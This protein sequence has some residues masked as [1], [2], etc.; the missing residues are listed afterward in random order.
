MFHQASIFH[1]NGLSATLAAGAF[2]VFS[3]SPATSSLVAGFVSD[4]IGPKA[5]LVFSMATLVAT[6]ALGVSINSLLVAVVYIVMMG[7]LQWVLHHRSQHHLGPL[8]RPPR[9]G[10]HSRAGH[11]PLRLC[12]G[13]RPL[14]LFQEL[15]GTYTL[16]MI[17]MMALPVLSLPV[18]LLTRPGQTS[19]PE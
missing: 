10:A 1:E 14:P 17:A 2:A 16:G 3:V 9:I 8:L 5:L 6:L 11:D 18:L 4:R 19:G 12:L 7:S 13:R 15:T